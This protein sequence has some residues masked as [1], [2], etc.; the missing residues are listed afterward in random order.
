MFVSAYAAISG[1][2]TL[3]IADSISVD[4]H[5]CFTPPQDC[6][7]SASQWS[8]YAKDRLIVTY[9]NQCDQRL[10]LKKCNVRKNGT[11]DCGAA[12]LNAGQTTKWSTSEAMDRYHFKVVGALDKRYDRICADKQAD[13]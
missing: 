8:T 4:Q 6:I 11:E 1:S 7:A 13:W 10:Y 5:G 9:T 2:V 12:G 3:N